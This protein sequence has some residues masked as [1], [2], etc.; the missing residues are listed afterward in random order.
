MLTSDKTPAFL[1][2][3]SQWLRT[4]ARAALALG[5]TSAGS[6]SLLRAQ[7]ALELQSDFGLLDGSVAAM[8]GVAVGVSPT[9]RIFDLTHQIPAY[10]I[11]AAAYRLHQTVA[12]WP[13]GTVFVSI[14]DPGVGTDRKSV[15]VRTSSGQYVVTPD[16]GTLTFL[17]ES[18]GIAEVREIDERVN[19]LRGSERSH[20]FH[21]RDVYAYTG[22]RL[23][24]GVITFEK[25]GPRRTVSQLVRLPYSRPS[26]TDGVAVGAIVIHDLPYGNLWTNIDDRTFE[27]LGSVATARFDVRLFRGD[28]LAWRGVVPFVKSFGEV[29]PGQPLLYLNSLLDVAL[30]LNMGDFAR[31]FGIGA[32][33]EWR[34]EIRA[35]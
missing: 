6:A 19:R 22:A 21:G 17:A 5:V 35:P 16:N 33:G 12:Y 7:P 10:D 8:K 27:K 24:A 26:F 34:I 14:V 15:V 4:I 32:G 18:P 29:P 28:S 25:V 2:D 23:A 30:A 9:L 3:R 20:T 13:R 11:W 31:R 1:C